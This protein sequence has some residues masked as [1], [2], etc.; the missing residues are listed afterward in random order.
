MVNSENYPGG[1]KSRVNRAGENIR[2]GLDTPDDLTVIEEWRA[3]HRSVLN[4][5]QAILR[6]R[7]RGTNVTVAQRH[8]RK[9]TIFDKLNRLPG[10]QLSRMDDV[11][12]CRLIFRSIREL[13]KF[14]SSFQKARFKH[15]RRN[16]P[17]KYDY[18]SHPKAT[19]YR[20]IHDV[21][22]YNVNSETGRDLAGLYIEIQYRTL[23]QHAWATAVEVVGF[24]TES[25]P[26]F[27]QGDKRYEHEMALASEILARAHEGLNGPFPHKSNREL[28]EE[29]LAMDGELMLLATLKGLN[30]AKS[31]VSDKKNTILIFTR[32]G[33]LEV[34]SFRDAPEALRA[35]FVLEKEMPYND[36]VLVR[37]DSSDEVRL[38]FRNYFSDASEFI[39]LIEKACAKLSGHSSPA[40]RKKIG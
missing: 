16:S 21:Y 19:G 35:L 15:K 33:T 11:A 25:Q 36:I 10:M 29:F 39:R 37:A 32:E 38:A 1:S 27:Q 22:E 9:N 6:T 4:T 40:R 14:R 13:N 7:T 34:R 17:E 24:I 8:K 20:G 2:Y 5:F 31:E 3:A 28:L 12:G 18:I 26:K 23:V 30:Q